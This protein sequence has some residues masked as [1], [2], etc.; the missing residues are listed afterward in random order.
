MV[1]FT[2]NIVFDIKGKIID[3]QIGYTNNYKKVIKAFLPF[4]FNPE[5]LFTKATINIAIQNTFPRKIISICGYPTD[6]DPNCYVF[7]ITNIYT[8]Y[9][10]N[11]LGLMSIDIVCDN[12]KFKSHSFRGC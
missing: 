11:G 1:G 6:S 7:D 8:K 3:Q 5:N 4:S 12:Q 9:L 10:K 2:N